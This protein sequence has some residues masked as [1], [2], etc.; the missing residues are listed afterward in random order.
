[1][2]EE[3]VDEEPRDAVHAV[4]SASAPSVVA[5]PPARPQRVAA[6]P[7]RVVWAWTVDHDWLVAAATYT[8]ITLAI[9]FPLVFHLGDSIIG[10]DASGDSAWYVWYSWWVHQALAMG[11]DPAF[12]HLLY[13]LTPRVEIFAASTDNGV[14]GALL[15]T[16]LSPLAAYNLLMLLG[17]ALSGLAMYLLAHEFVRS[18]LACFVAG[19]LYSYTTDHFWR[20][21]GHLSLASL[22]W[23]P[24]LV[25]RTFVFY[26]RPSRGNAIWM[27]LAIA[28]VPLD[29][30]YLAA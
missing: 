16:A 28:F 18:R 4:P 1:V 14:L 5:Q 23:L 19:F 2:D 26:R 21:E 25:W 30:F 20:A 13:A 17:F 12:T 6:R 29:D 22:E 15:V 24:L 9:T 11:H 8:A 7:A 10:T 3:T 27:G